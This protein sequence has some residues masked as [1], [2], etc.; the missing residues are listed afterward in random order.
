MLSKGYKKMRDVKRAQKLHAPAPV[1]DGTVSKTPT[2]L[3]VNLIAN[4]TAQAGE[5]FFRHSFGDSLLEGGN[6]LC[7]LTPPSKV[8][9]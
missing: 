5:D 3:S 6:S 7:W 8:S 1:I 9:F 2:K 4:A